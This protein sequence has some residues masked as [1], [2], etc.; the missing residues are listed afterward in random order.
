VIVLT[1][2]SYV[3]IGEHPHDP[4][5]LL[6]RGRFRGDVDRFLLAPIELETP[7]EDYR[8]QA[9]AK[10]DDVSAALARNIREIRYQTVLQGIRVS[11]RLALAAAV[12][13][14]MAAA[15]HERQQIPRAPEDPGFRNAVVEEP[16]HLPHMDQRP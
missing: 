6:V 7:D 2:N 12:N 9:A 15:Q 11:W 14:L 13:R 10:R 1:Q 16:W 5:L 4:A 3:H 8:Y